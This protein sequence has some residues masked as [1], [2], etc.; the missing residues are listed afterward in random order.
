M[1][2]MTEKFL[3]IMFSFK[4]KK[5]QTFIFMNSFIYLFLHVIFDKLEFLFLHKQKKKSNDQYKQF[6]CSCSNFLKSNQ[7]FFF[8]NFYAIKSIH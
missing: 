1:T 8:L 3:L 6:F 4:K 5:S 7:F 2:I